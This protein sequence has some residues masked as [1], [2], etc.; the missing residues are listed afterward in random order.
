MDKR[1]SL[2]NDL[3]DDLLVLNTDHVPLKDFNPDHSINLWWNG[4]NRRPNQH[5]RKQYTAHSSHD[6]DVTQS[7]VDDD[8]DEPVEML[9][10]WNEWLS[11]ENYLNSE[12]KDFM[13]LLL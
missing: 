12:T 11:T 5:P 9:H 3:L 6:L 1:S 4:K 8:D 13:H 7:D 10:E 2:G